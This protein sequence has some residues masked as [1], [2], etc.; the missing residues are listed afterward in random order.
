MHALGCLIIEDFTAGEGTPSGRDLS[1]GLR[2]GG[3]EARAFARSPQ[4]A[5]WPALQTALQQARAA[6]DGACLV[7]AGSGCAA[8]L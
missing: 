2:A 8:A 6:H 4:E 7:A 5:L 3:I 1:R